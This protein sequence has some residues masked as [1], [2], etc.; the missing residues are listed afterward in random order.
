[1]AHFLRN[2]TNVYRLARHNIKRSKLGFS[3]QGHHVF[4]DVGNVQKCSIVARDLFV[5]GE[6]K[7]ATGTTAGLGLAVDNQ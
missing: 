1:M 5:V 6:E 4:D 7:V 3:G 2:D